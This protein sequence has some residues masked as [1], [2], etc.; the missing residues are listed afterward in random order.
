MNTIYVN[1]YA[2]YTCIFMHAYTQHTIYIYNYIMYNN[3]TNIKLYNIY[4]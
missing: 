2:N 3:F 4:T 1:T